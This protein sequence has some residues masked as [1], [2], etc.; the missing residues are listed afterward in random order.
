MTVLFNEQLEPLNAVELRNQ[1]LKSNDEN[2]TRNLVDVTEE[3]LETSLLNWYNKANQIKRS[4]LTK[5]TSLQ[6][7][8]VDSFG[9]KKIWE[10]IK[11]ELCKKLN[12]DS[13]PEKIVDAILSAISAIIPGAI[14][15]KPLLD[16]LV[17]FVLKMGYSR[18]CPTGV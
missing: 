14:I 5:A 2:K 9:I 12:P 3:D 17:R 4:N 16:K 15:I 18:L 6:E 8:V 1:L 13:S 10:K 11:A 7:N